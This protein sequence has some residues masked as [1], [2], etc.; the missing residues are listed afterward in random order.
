MSLAHM[1][2]A[3]L[4]AHPDSPTSC[5]RRHNTVLNQEVAQQIVQ[6]SLFTTLDTNRSN[7]TDIFSSG[8][9]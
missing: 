7:S 4:N 3:A 8:V 5:V 6:Y 9:C 1:I 2:V